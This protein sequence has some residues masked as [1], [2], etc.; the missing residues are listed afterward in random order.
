[1]AR[2]SSELENNILVIYI[3]EYIRLTAGGILKHS[4]QKGDP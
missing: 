1:V 3:Y 4:V 2:A